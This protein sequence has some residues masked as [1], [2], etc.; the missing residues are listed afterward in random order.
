[1]KFTIL[2]VDRL[3]ILALF[4]T[5]LSSFTFAAPTA[6][7]PTMEKRALPV[8]LGLA[9]SFGALSAT[10]LT[11]TG[12]TAIT[13][14]G[15]VG[16]GGVYPGTAIDG[17][18]PGTA[19]GTLGRG[20]TAAQNGQAACLVAYNNGLSIVPTKALPSADL[21]GLTVR[22]GAYTFPTSQ[23]ALSGNLTLD[24][25]GIEERQFIF[26]ITTTFTVAAAARVVLTNGAR[27]CNVYFLVGTSASIGAAAQLQGNMIAYTA[28]AAK[29]GASN[30]GTWCALNAAVTLINNALVAQPGYCPAL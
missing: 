10:T 3:A 13:G 2:S 23:V 8:L 15:A 26:K 24:A 1:M 20:S 21:A 11:S 7:E 12:N 17:F 27:P 5:H 9:K 16:N 18:P 29:A 25:G 6:K 22:P 19:S 30:K 4:A 28:I 14:T